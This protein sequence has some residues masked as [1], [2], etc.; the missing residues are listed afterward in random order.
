L[1]EVEPRLKKLPN[2]EYVGEVGGDYRLKLL[3]EAECL[4]FP[5]SWE[6]PFGLV[7]V[8]AMACGTPVIALDNGAVSEV[9]KS[10]PSQICQ[11]IDE[12]IAQLHGSSDS[13][14]LRGYVSNHFTVAH[15]T[16]NYLSLYKK[17]IRLFMDQKDKKEISE[18]LLPAAEYFKST[19]EF[20]QA[21]SLYERLLDSSQVEHDIKVFICNEVADIYHQLTDNEKERE[22]CY[23]SFQYDTPRAEICCRLG[24]YFLQQN[25]LDQAVFWYI[26][27][28]EL[29]LPKKK[30]MLYYEACWTW[31]PHVQLCVCFYRLGNYEKAYHHNEEARKHNPDH[32]HIVTNK[33]L[34]ESVL[35]VSSD[36]TVQV[37]LKNDNEEPFLMNL[38]LP[39]FIEET[40]QRKGFW[41]P[42]LI[43]TLRRYLQDGGVFLDVGANIGYHALH[44]ASLHSK[45][46]CI[47][48]EPHPEIF[49]QLQQNIEMNSFSNVT[50]HQ[51]AVGKTVGQTYFH[52]Q[53]SNN[54]NRGM[55]AIDYYDGI[56]TDYTTVQV[57]TTTLDAFLG[58]ETKSKVKLIKIDTQGHEYQ[59]IQGALDLINTSQ[60]VITLEHHDNDKKSIHDISEL[61]PNYEIY[62]VNFWNG[63][64]E[65][66]EEGRSEEFMDDYV[67][68][69]LHIKI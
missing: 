25:Q 32:E 15:M 4:L 47:C 65:R 24:Y 17:V 29:G 40:I 43:K 38:H 67:L 48:F 50:A 11:N 10:Y 57:P 45:I 58:I 68:V 64:M 20:D 22:S 18:Y 35:N 19:K 27:A 39:G 8:E 36:H 44:A 55:S 26:R 13:S 53:N 34:L 49:E 12:M 41:E 3:R 7:M 69:P 60:P 9:L 61:L 30:T 52:M 51:I 56:G 6:E 46:E 54:Y 2:V 5:T 31:L 63:K 28:T 23:R 1:N 62:R 66:F 42:Y 14:S 21:I 33:E 59:V 37:E 16:E